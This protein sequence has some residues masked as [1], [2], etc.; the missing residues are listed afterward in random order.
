LHL[1]SLALGVLAFASLLVLP[2]TWLTF[3]L[4]GGDLSFWPRLWIGAA[5]SPVVVLVQYYVVRLLGASFDLTC[6]ILLVLN[7]PAGYV[8]A[9]GARG[10]GVLAVDVRGRVVAVAAVCVGVFAVYFAHRTMFGHSWMHADIVYQLAN[11]HLRPEDPVLAGVRLAYP[12]F[13]HPQPALF[14]WLVGS[15]SL[16]TYMWPNVAYLTFTLCLTWCVVRTLGGDD[17]ATVWS[18]I[19]ILFGV[20]LVGYTL[21]EV[22]PPRLLEILPG[23]TGF[24]YTPWIRR[25]LSFEQEQTVL[26]MFSALLYLAVDRPRADWSKYRWVLATLLLC[27]LGVIYTIVLPAAFSIVSAMGVV[28]FVGARTPRAQAVRRLLPLGLMVIVASVV[29]FATVRW[30]TQDSTGGVGVGLDGWKEMIKKGLVMIIVLFPLLVG[31]LVALARR[32]VLDLDRRLV[33]ALAGVQCMLLF[34]LFQISQ[35]GGNEYKFAFIAAAALAPLAALAVSGPMIRMGRAALPLTLAGLVVFAAPAFHKWW[36]TERSGKRQ[37]DIDSSQFDIR[38]RSG[39]FA[40]VSDAL[41]GH[42]PKNTMVVVRDPGIHLPT[43]TQRA[44]YAPYSDEYL[45]GTNLKGDL[46]LSN[47]KGYPAALLAGRRDVLKGLYEPAAV[48]SRSTSL[49]QLQSMGRPL[50]V[51]VDEARDA[52]LS[53][54]FAGTVGTTKLYEGSGLTVWL[55][56]SALAP[57]SQPR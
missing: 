9:R 47:V 28:L 20:N 19:L 26:P 49:T 16:A 6:W 33:P 12:W 52:G 29:T 36:T 46:M 31:A 15:S 42:T 25:F 10:A 7:L 50:G 30:V 51:V 40:G 45:A 32:P 1:L 17:H 39:P 27:G 48:E 13:G 35:G 8:V 55:V 23:M 43:L 44:L 57:T 53:T 22:L 56:N 11:G 18:L 54:F 38:L 21:G 2:G 5:L 24:R 4:P 14:S 41:R 37:V 3:C 34:A